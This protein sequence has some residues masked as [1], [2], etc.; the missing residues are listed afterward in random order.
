LLVLAN[1]SKTNCVFNPDNYGLEFCY[2]FDILLLNMAQK[3]YVYFRFC[4]LK[5]TY[6]L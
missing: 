3:K 6:F 1:I 4:W 2:N 5:F